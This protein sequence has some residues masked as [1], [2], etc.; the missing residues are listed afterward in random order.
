[1]SE[2]KTDFFCVMCNF[3]I[4]RPGRLLAIKTFAQSK[5]FDLVDI[6]N[7]HKISFPT[8]YNTS[9]SKFFPGSKFYSTIIE[10]SFVAPG[11]MYGLVKTH[12]ADN[13]IR[14]ITSGCG[15]A[16]ENLSIFAEKCLFPE[17]LKIESRVQDTSEMLDF[18]DF[19]K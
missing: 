4:L 19:F 18:I 17:L 13:P 10:P 7:L 6:L 8:V 14:A 9:L 16:V 2:R 3:S 5:N 1:M 11:K 12:K 15:T